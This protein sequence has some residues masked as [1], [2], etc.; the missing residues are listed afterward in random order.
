MTNIEDLKKTMDKVT[1][2][3]VA[4]NVDP[5]NEEEILEWVETTPK[6][7]ALYKGG[8]EFYTV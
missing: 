1:Q 8:S 6:A 3:T 2:R 4:E 7:E 5:I